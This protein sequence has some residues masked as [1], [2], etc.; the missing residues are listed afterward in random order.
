MTS[1]RFPTLEDFPV[2]VLDVRADASPEACQRLG[3]Y[4]LAQV[5]SLIERLRH[6]RNAG[7]SGH[8]RQEVLLSAMEALLMDA[9]L[10]YAR[11]RRPA[12]SKA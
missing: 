2:D 3:D 6:E 11:A 4:R 7:A 9:H 5:S 1:H 8:L 12:V 10:M